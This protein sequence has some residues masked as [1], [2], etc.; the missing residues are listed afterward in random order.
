MACIL[1]APPPSTYVVHKLGFF[2]GMYMDLCRRIYR[3]SPFWEGEPIAR[4]LARR[5]ASTPPPPPTASTAAHVPS[6]NLCAQ[7]IICMLYI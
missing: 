3:R 2:N 6:H 1:H 7:F 5:V 4:D